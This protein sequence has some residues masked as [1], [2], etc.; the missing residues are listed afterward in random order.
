[1]LLVWC[2]GAPPATQEDKVLVLV[3][4]VGA[5]PVRPDCEFAK[6]TPAATDGEKVL[7]LARDWPRTR[8][9]EGEL[10]AVIE[11]CW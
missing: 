7:A 9:Y 10:E 2:S 1:M 8:K 6:L 11:G 3:P 4:C 5:V